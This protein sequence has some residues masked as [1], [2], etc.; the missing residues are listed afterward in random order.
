MLAPHRL[1]EEE[2]TYDNPAA[3]QHEVRES[4]YE[5][6]SPKGFGDYDFAPSLAELDTAEDADMP[7]TGEFQRRN[8][9]A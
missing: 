1:A 9:F 2:P 4:N 3:G 5:L 6:A 8:S 7:P